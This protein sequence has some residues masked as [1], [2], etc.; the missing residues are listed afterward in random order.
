MLM[1]FF[2][3][4]ASAAQDSGG[5]ASDGGNQRQPRLDLTGFKT[6]YGSDGLELRKRILAGIGETIAQGNT[7]DDIYTALEYMSM[8]GLKNRAM[9][10]GVMLNNYPDIRREVAIQLGKAGTAKATE[11]LIKICNSE[12]DHYVLMETFKSL[13]DI[14]INENDL[15]VKNIIWALRKY[16][17]RSPDGISDQVVLAAI[18]AL[19]KIDKK[20]DGIQSQKELNDVHDFLSRVSIG[21]F[22]RPTQDRAKQVM[23]EMLQRNAQRR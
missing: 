1:A 17:P 8:E 19:E 20:D 9:E 23:A 6:V 7:G 18:N 2:I 4:S 21:Q 13:G 22:Y 16:N 3:V 5:K 15:T 11:I 14:G 12:T 10:R